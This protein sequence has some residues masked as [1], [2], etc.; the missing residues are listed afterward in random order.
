PDGKGGTLAHVADHIQ[1][2]LAVGGSDAVAIGTDLDG[3]TR[4]PEGFSGVQDFPMIQREL[5]RRGM[6][7]ETIE[8]IAWKNAARV[9]RAALGREETD[10]GRG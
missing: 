7:A 5:E 10:S 8:R 4:L 9:L 2:A 6:S 3:I 1:H